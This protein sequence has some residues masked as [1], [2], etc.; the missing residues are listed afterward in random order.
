MASWGLISRTKHLVKEATAQAINDKSFA[1]LTAL[2]LFEKP[3][4][5]PLSEG[6]QVVDNNSVEARTK[7]KTAK[8]PIDIKT[9]T[10]TSRS[11][12]HVVFPLENLS[13]E[14]EQV[15]FE[16][17]SLDQPAKLWYRTMLLNQPVDTID[18]RVA[19]SIAEIYKDHGVEGILQVILWATAYR[20]QSGESVFWRK[21]EELAGEYVKGKHYL[22]L[23]EGCLLELQRALGGKPTFYDGTPFI[24]DG[25]CFFEYR[26]GRGLE[27]KS[28][29]DGLSMLGVDDL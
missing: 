15:Q 1:P 20:F 22:V 25:E 4:V 10:S 26:A 13:D 27:L 21:V 14:F 24:V 5:E 2:A 19:E 16:R 28:Y 6:W 29:A 12:L 23:V 11:F 18:T 3:K 7:R 8:P 9:E 17:F